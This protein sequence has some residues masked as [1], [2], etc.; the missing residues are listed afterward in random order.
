MNYFKVP[1]FLFSFSHHFQ[2]KTE[3]L[4]EIEKQPSNSINNG[5]DNISHTDW[6]ANSVP[7][8]NIFKDKFIEEIDNQF[9]ELHIGSWIIKNLWFQKYKTNDNHIWHKHGNSHWACVYYLNLPDGCPGTLLQDPLTNNEISLN[10]REGDI[11]I[12]PSQIWHCSPKNLSNKEKIIIAC[13]ID[14]ND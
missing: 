3:I 7:Y 9:K 6:S 2:F 12:F 11:F 8:F 13:N 1:Y 10:Q 14:V 5:R 4:K